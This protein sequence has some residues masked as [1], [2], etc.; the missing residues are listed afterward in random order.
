MNTQHLPITELVSA[1]GLVAA[2]TALL[3]VTNAAP[4]VAVA[5]LLVVL[6]SVVVLVGRGLSDSG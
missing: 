5:V 3:N 4:G 1:L 2:T 6:V